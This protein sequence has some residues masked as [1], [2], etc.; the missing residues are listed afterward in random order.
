MKKFL[1]IAFLFV[2][3]VSM[4]CDQEKLPL[5]VSNIT[6]TSFGAN[7]TSYIELFP[8]WNSEH[9]GYSLSQPQD[10]IIGPDGLIFLA[11]KGNNRVLTLTKAGDRVNRDGLGS[12][13]PSHPQNLAIDSRLNL[14][15][16]NQ[17]D[18]L[19]GWNQ[20]LNSVAIEKVAESGIFY[21]PETQETITLTI[22][23]YSLRVAQGNTSLQPQ[24][25]N[26]TTDSDAIQRVKQIYPVYVAQE[27]GSQFNGVTAGPYGQFNVYISETTYDKIIQ[28]QLIPERIVMT[29][30]GTMLF[31]HRGLFMNNPV[32]FGSGAGTADHPYSLL[33]D[34][35]G[36]LYFSQLGGNFRVQKL[37]QGSYSPAY[38]LYQHDIMDL[39]R[40]ETPYDLSLDDDGNLFV[41]DAA[42]RSVSKFDNS[43]QGAGNLMNLGDKGLAVTEFDNPR[44]IM[45]SENIVYVVESGKNRIRRFQYSVSDSDLPDD[46][47]KP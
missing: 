20:Y 40:F 29:A 13:E 34:R 2:L 19:Y 18:T 41:V 43:G 37:F 27:S 5:P 23:E 31:Q 1:Y 39:N 42:S 44:G 45:I 10:I 32:S 16:T 9:L 28:I 26:Y 22:F 8:V 46:D 38:V 11:D 30:N 12:L 4:A 3:F 17:S 14:F 25:L 33:T 21:D 35:E 15:M 6:P 7:D 36:N 47:K 24:E